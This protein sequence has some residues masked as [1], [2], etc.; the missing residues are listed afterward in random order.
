MRSREAVLFACFIAAC[1]FG[2]WNSAHADVSI[3][4]RCSDPQQGTSTLLIHGEIRK[5]DAATF[6]T[7]ADE[8]A[9]NTR[10]LLGSPPNGVPFIFVKLDSPGGDIIESLAVEKFDDGLWSLG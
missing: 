8:L 7:K 5:G 2:Q 6:T 4:R 9:K 1:W 3:T 10:C